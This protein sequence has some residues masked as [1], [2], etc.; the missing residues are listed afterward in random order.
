MTQKLELV[1]PKFQINKIEKKR[2]NCICLIDEIDSDSHTNWIYEFLLPHLLPTSKRNFKICFVLAGSGSGDM[3]KMKEKIKSKNKRKDLLDRISDDNQY[4][5]ST[6]N[7][8]DRFLT[9]ASQV[10]NKSTEKSNFEI[11]K[12]DKLALFYILVN[13][14]YSTQRQIEQVVTS[15]VLRV[16]IGED[17]MSYDAL[18]QYG[19]IDNK[20]FWLQAK[21]TNSKLFNSFIHIKKN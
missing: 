19:D 13:S 5:I 4:T 10:L 8:G 15:A 7:I 11:N 9:I 21:T 3:D 18:F 6:P 16:P 17:R 1:M 20:E 14:K 12:I 2:K